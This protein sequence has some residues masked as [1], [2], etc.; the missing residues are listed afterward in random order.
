MAGCNDA[1]ARVLDSLAML[2]VAHG[3]SA[4]LEMLDEKCFPMCVQHTAPTLPMSVCR[5]LAQMLCVRVMC[6]Q[7]CLTVS[8][9]SQ[10]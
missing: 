7:A 4:K 2:C 3:R 8:A 6:V 9:A 10:A 1:E 5:A